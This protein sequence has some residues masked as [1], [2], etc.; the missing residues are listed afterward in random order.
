M[1]GPLRLL[2]VDDE[3]AVQRA[4]A[5]TLAG[6]DIAIDCCSGVAEA[7]VAMQHGRYDVVATDMSMGDGTGLDVLHACAA[8]L[9]G[10]VRVVVSGDPNL[11]RV[12]AGFDVDDV[13]AK[14]WDVSDLRSRI[15]RAFAL[16]AARVR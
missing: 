16:A 4:F 6:L 14:P 3:A 2:F 1:S 5:R 9:P 11:G 12:L 8:H 7:V 13:I 15:E 10:V